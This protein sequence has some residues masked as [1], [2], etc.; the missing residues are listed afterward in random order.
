MR[1]LRFAEIGHLANIIKLMSGKEE[2]T[3]PI[4]MVSMGSDSIWIY[5]NF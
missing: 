2:D 1:K 4:T 5:N 3:L